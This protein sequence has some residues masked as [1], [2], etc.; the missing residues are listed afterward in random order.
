M[1]LVTIVGFSLIAI[2]IGMI[3]TAFKSKTPISNFVLGVVVVIVGICGL[4]TLPH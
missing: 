2:G 4:G 3:A 1:N